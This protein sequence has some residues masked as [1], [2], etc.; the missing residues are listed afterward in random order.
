MLKNGETVRA[1]GI[2]GI[3][4]NGLLLSDRLSRL[5]QDFPLNVRPD[6]LLDRV[7]IQPVANGIGG[8]MTQARIMV[9]PLFSKRGFTTTRNTNQNVTLNRII[10]SSM[11]RLQLK[12]IG[13]LM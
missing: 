6:S 10:H 3:V 2:G 5:L 13:I 4:Q 8:D 12:V 1:L 11:I 9:T 7:T